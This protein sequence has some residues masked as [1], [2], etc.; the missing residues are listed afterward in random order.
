MSQE[1]GLFLFIVESPAPGIALAQRRHSGNTDCINEG[2]T[3]PQASRVHSVNGGRV[4]TLG[5]DEQAPV[6]SRSLWC[7]FSPRPASSQK[8]LEQ[9]VFCP[10]P[11]MCPAPPASP[12]TPLWSLRG[13]TTN[14]VMTLDRASHHT[15]EGDAPNLGCGVSVRA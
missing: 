7:R 1:Q 15:V 10:T 6:Q 5:T 3:P 8:T 4:K 11:L 14:W 2:I 9:L 13:M 12:A